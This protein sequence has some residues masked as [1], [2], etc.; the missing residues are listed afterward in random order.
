MRKRIFLSLLVVA[1]ILALARTARAAEQT[2]RDKY[3][4]V[5]VD[6]FEV[7]EGVQL[8]ADYLPALQ[9]D[10]VKRLQK[11][12]TFTEV[13]QPGESPTNPSEPVLRLNGTITHFEPGSRGKRYI[14][15]GLGQT[16][17]TARL[18][19]SDRATA[20]PLIVE[21][22]QGALTGGFA[23]GKSKNVTHNF[24]K[25]LA[26][27]CKVVLG[28]RLPAPGEAVTTE[29]ASAATSEGA[30]RHVVKLSSKDFKG[31]EKELNEHAAMG[32]RLVEY[33]VTAK[34][35]ARLTMEKLPAIE[36]PPEY[37]VLHAWRVGSIEKGL[38]KAAAE[39]FHL[40]PQT[41]GTFGPSMSVIVERTAQ[42]KEP[43]RQY[44]VRITKRV[45][46]LQ[47]KIEKDQAE[48]YKLVDT[49]EHPKQ[50]HLAILEKATAKSSD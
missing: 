11:S 7:A 5:E 25:T 4:V 36:R 23:G 37:R 31:S 30:E 6:Q 32:F 15:F 13:L 14:G 10:V 50:G 43:L 27:T 28:K 33:A 47:N 21:Q 48:G 16:R 9:E 39:G 17:I 38:N 26:I 18:T 44:R 22:I 29:T 49:W 45:S 24:A 41:A 19:F 2:I 35:T 20:Q 40:T 42:V 12:K 1:G 46:S 34:D 3:R 8:P